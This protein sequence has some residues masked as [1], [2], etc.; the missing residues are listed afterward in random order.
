M[1]LE[2]IW[3]KLGRQPLYEEIRKPLSKYSVDVYC[4]RF[5]GWLEAC[6]SFIKHK[7]GDVEFEKSIKDAIFKLR[8]RNIN[9]RDRLKIF[10]RENYRCVICGKSPVTHQKIT[11]HIDHIKPFSR[12][13]DNSLENLR[14][15]CDK[16]NLAKG[17]EEDI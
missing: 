8:T 9:E 10:K 3:I 14:T 5:G 1:D 15:L 7:K 4:R 16:C 11:L 13:G 17:N 12:E 6:K 2:L